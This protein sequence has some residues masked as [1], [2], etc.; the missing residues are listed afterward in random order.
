[1][2]KNKRD[3][4][5]GLVFFGGLVLLIWATATLSNLS[6]TEKQEIKV[7]FA[8]AKGLRIGEPVYVLGS[9][10]G[11]VKRVETLPNQKD[12]RVRVTLQFDQPITFKKD[13]TVKI[14]DA[15]FLGGKKIDIDPGVDP[16][17]HPSEKL[18]EGIALETPLEVLSDMVAG[19]GNKDNLREI[20][21]GVRKFIDDLNSSEGTIHKLI[22]EDTIYDDAL[23]IVESL[24]KS[25]EEL[26]QGKG[27]L[28]RAIYD[29]QLGQ[30]LT[31]AMA[32]ISEISKKVNEGNGAIARLINDNRLGENLD[33]IV[34]DTQQVIEKLKKGE[35]AIGKLLSDPE[36]EKKVT[37][38]MDN[39]V[40]VSANL[41]NPEAGLLGRAIADPE[42][43]QKAKAI[44]DD[45]AAITKEVRE[46]EG[47]LARL[48]H[49]E[50]LSRRVDSMFKQI[51]RAIED[52]REAA[53]VGT[54]FQVFSGT[55]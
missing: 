2:D 48:I 14:A 45:I 51:T 37:A 6:F 26:E 40:Q 30:N 53:P 54:F 4:L 10:N 9:Q 13:Y 18:M 8:N 33:S 38:F 25:A 43:G 24:K 39:M 36:T 50:D 20:L 44:F 42:M 49:D 1:M 27:L 52:A 15:S 11:Q 29:E 16:E 12:L 23:A 41:N 34:A 47:L 22:H 28:G 35:G 31:E 5:L 46:G 32:D 17:L 19:E 21:A 55:F 7:Q 3:T